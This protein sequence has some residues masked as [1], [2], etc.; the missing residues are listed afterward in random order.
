MYISASQK[1]LRHS[2]VSG[3]CSQQFHPTASVLIVGGE[4]CITQVHW[5]QP[6]WPPC[7]IFYS[8]DFPSN[9]LTLKQF[10]LLEFSHENCIHDTNED[11]NDVPPTQGWNFSYLMCTTRHLMLIPLFAPLLRATSTEF[12]SGGCWLFASASLGVSDV[13]A[14]L[15]RMQTSAFSN[16]KWHLFHHVWNSEIEI[17]HVSYRSVFLWRWAVGSN[18]SSQCLHS[19]LWAWRSLHHQTVS[20]GGAVLVCWSNRTGTFWHTT[21]RTPRLQW[22]S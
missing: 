4:R 9:H 8:C 7:S 14:A 2:V 20:A 22:V 6:G 19:F 21:A 10:A 12:F 17:E 11:A 3:S 1:P 13:I 16:N 5:P 18:W 15:K